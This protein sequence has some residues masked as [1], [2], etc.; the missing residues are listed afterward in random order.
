MLNCFISSSVRNPGSLEIASIIFFFVVPSSIMLYTF[1]LAIMLLI[2]A[3]KQNIDILNKLLN[4]YFGYSSIYVFNFI[5]TIIIYYFS[6]NK[7]I[8]N[9]EEVFKWCIYVLFSIIIALLFIKHIN[10][11]IFKFV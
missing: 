2:Y 1:Y 9:Y 8:Y 10:F 7:K 5:A 3:R 6:I 11:R 4:T